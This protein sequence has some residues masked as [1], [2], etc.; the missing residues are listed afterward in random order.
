[1]SS[2]GLCLIVWPTHPPHGLTF[3]ACK[4]YFIGKFLSNFDLK[5]MI[6]IYTKDF[7]CQKK[8]SK[9]ARF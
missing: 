2:H 5:N 1:M 6:L 7:S 4:V 9:L 3:E 8:W